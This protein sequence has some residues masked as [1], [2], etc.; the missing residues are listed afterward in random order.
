MG[1]VLMYE[2]ALVAGMGHSA[3][4]AVPTLSL[5]CKRAAAARAVAVRGCCHGVQHGE[6]ETW[7]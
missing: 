6:L 7:M 3:A 1:V 5:H 2:A 4:A